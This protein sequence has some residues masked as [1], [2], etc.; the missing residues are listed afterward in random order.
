MMKKQRR[1]YLLAIL[2]IA[3]CGLVTVAHSYDLLLLLPSILAGAQQGTGTAGRQPL[4]DTGITW[5]GNYM[6]GNNSSCVS[7]TTSYGDNVVAAQ[8]CSYG[9]D[10]D[11]DDDSDGYAG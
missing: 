4:N 8:D 6:S 7:S 3:V 5:S 1:S 9:R 2:F 10:A 11:H